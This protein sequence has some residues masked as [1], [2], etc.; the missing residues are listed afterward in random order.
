MHTGMMLI[1]AL[2]LVGLNGFFVAAEF[3][4]VK[5]RKTRLHLLA[6]SGD[7]RAQSALF[8]ESHL[9]AYLSV[10]QLGITLASLG[11]GWLGEPA[12][13]VLLKPLLAMLYVDNPALIESLSFI[14][15]FSIITFLHVVFGELAP[16]SISI[17]KAEAAVLLAARPMR[18]FYVLCLPLVMVMNGISNLLLRLIGINQTSETEHAHSAEELRMLI[19]DSSKGG[20]LDKDEGR[21]LDNIF[22]FYQKTVK[23]IMVHRMDTVALDISEK[24]AVLLET[25]EKSG[26]TRFPVYENNRDD[27]IGFVHIKDIMRSNNATLRP[28]LRAPVYAPETLRLDLLLHRMQNKRQ[29]FCVVIDEYGVWQGVL[30]MEDIV[31]AIVGDIQDE[32]DKE[33]PDLV[34]EADGT[35]LISGDIAL[36]DLAERINLQGYDKNLDL[37]KIIAARFMEILE[38]IPVEGDFID[39]CGKR[40]TV[41]EMDKNRV[42]HIRVEDVPS[43]EPETGED[44]A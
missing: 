25:A 38:R 8:G 16:K 26:H 11:L 4:F 27:I 36:G 18:V 39:I 19:L 32:F 3:A 24:K 2:F 43:P 34:V 14:I 40:F 28:I 41:V 23:D 7:K 15:G 20:Q 21:M 29:Q 37:H 35:Y 9:N 30:S 33:E 12:V 22:S 10:C 31:E 17:Q 1:L 13:A 42:R 44:N 5:A 6:E